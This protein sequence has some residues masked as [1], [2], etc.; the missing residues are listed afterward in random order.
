M[1]NHSDSFKLDLPES[2]WRD[3]KLLAYVWDYNYCPRP[4]SEIGECE[5]PIG[6]L[7]SAPEGTW[8]NEKQPLLTEK[9]FPGAGELLVFV[10]WRK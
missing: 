5:I 9:Q 7:F 4:N 3:L 2:D 8:I 6:H 1:W 10:Q